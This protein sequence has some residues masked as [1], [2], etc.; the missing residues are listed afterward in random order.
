MGAVGVA[1]A[2]PSGLPR[3]NLELAPVCAQRLDADFSSFIVTGQGGRPPEG[4]VAVP[5]SPGHPRADLYK[6]LGDLG[7]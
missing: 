3:I 1:V 5:T 4:T 6:E 7:L 2:L